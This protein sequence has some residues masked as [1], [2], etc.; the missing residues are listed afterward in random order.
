MVLTYKSF[1]PSYANEEENVAFN[2]V[3]DFD[4][5]LVNFNIDSLLPKLELNAGHMTLVSRSYL[6][7]S[8]R[9]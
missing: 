6:V 2:W 7:G 9:D 1:R 5:A 3:K 8:M 4:K